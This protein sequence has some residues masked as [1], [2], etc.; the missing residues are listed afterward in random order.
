[1][2]ASL[3]KYLAAVLLAAVLPVASMLTWQVWHDLQTQQKQA[4]DELLRSATALAGSIDRELAS[5]VDAL[6][7]LSQSEIFQ[8]GR[9]AAMGRLLQGRPRRDWDSIFLLDANGATVLDTAQ[10]GHSL[11]RDALRDLHA[12][13]LKSRGAVVSGLTG[14]PGVAIALPILQADRVRYVLG[15]RTSDAVWTRLAMN[16]SHPEEG[17]A[18]LFDA[19]GRLISQSSAGAVPAGARLARESLEAMKSHASGVQRTAGVDGED[20]YAGWA[21]VPLSG[22][23]ARVAVPAEPIDAARRHAIVAALSTSGLSLLVGLVLAALV[24]SRIARPLRKLAAE[25]PK[26]LEGPVAVREIGMLRDALAQNAADSRAFL[27]LLG[28]ELRN[29]IG[30]IAAAADVLETSDADGAAAKEARSIIARQSQQLAQ[31]MHD[32]LEVGRAIGGEIRLSRAPLDLAQAV[33]HA[34]EVLRLTGESKQRRIDLDLADVWVEA[35]A[36]VLGHAL[37][38]LLIHAIRCTPASRDVRV[39]VRRDG[40]MAELEVRDA[41]EGIALTLARKVAELHGGTGAIDASPE[42]SRAIVRLP[43]IDAPAAPNEGALAPSRRR[44]VLLLAGDAD[45]LQALRSKLEL[46]GHSVVTGQDG[47]EGLSRLLQMRPDVSIVDVA[48]PGLGGF[49]LARD[50]RAAGYSGRMIALSAREGDTRRA[51]VAGF[52]ACLATPVDR[53]MLRTTIAAD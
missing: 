14:N 51:L 7:V 27:A 40:A 28:H 32:L 31:S 47:V 20:V 49:D 9:I 33:R 26:S 46:E 3:R 1:M 2:T 11:P 34:S 36:A 13:A 18:R 6:T 45:V 24:A 15:V 25:G 50:A 39:Q 21:A 17:V 22:W 52:D 10:R 53:E 4:E 35:D 37:G 16:A 30:A 23:S 5:S 8:Q 19:D 12:R 42:G 29:P 48:L 38:R 44:Q 41:R 43:A